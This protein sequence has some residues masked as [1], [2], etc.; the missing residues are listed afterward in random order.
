M[1]RFCCILLL[2]L[3]VPAAAL[4]GIVERG[5]MVHGTHIAAVFWALQRGLI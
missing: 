5:E 3:L 2:L 4:V 1:I